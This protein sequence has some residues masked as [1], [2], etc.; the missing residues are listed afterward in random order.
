MGDFNGDFEVTVDDLD[1]ILRNVYA[2]NF[3]PRGYNW[4]LD[5]TNDGV[6][7]DDDADYVVGN[8]FQTRRGDI[9][10]DFDVDDDDYDILVNNFGTGST[11]AEGDLNGDGEVDLTDF[12]IFEDNY[13][14]G[15]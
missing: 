14:W 12:V 13:P 8:Y 15:N 11:W 3:G 6:I 10:L 1:L 2:R 9:D 4:R 5:V 7:D